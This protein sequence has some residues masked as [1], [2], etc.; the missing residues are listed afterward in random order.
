MGKMLA[1]W[2]NDQG[3]ACCIKSVD[4]D[5]GYIHYGGA[6]DWA[7]E[8]RESWLMYVFEIPWVQ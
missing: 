7:M 1:P 3:E 5:N 4:V 2:T 8:G 6:Y